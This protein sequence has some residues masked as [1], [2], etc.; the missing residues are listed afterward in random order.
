MKTVEQITFSS[1][2]SPLIIIATVIV[3]FL[4]IIPFSCNFEKKLVAKTKAIPDKVDFNLH[5]KPILSDRCF[6][7]HGPDAASREAGLRL[8]TEE[9]AFAALG[10]TEEEKHYAIIAGDVENSTLIQ[11]IYS[12]DPA[13]IM[14]TPESNLTVSEYEKT[15]LKKWVAQGAEWKEHWS[16]LPIEEPEI[17]KVEGAKS[18]QPIDLFILK[19]L[20]NQGLKSVGQ[21]KKEHLIRRVT[22]S[23]TGLPPTIAEI[24]AFLQDNNPDAYE[25]VV[26]RLLT[27]DAYAENMT[28][29]WLDIARYADSHG[30]QDDLERVMFPWR[31]WVIHAFKKNM[32]YD[33]FVTWQL[34]GDL[35][36]NATKEQII[37]TGFNRN[38][39]ITQ[40]GGVIPEEYRVEYV[41]D[42]TQTFATAFLGL[43]YEC[44]KCH[45]HKYDAIAQKDYFS[46]F[47]FFNNVPEK[48][49]IDY[50]EIPEP[51]VTLSKEEIAETLTFINNA[52]TLEEIK[53]MVM[54]EM[55]EP[56]QAHILARGAYDKPTTP[57][58]PDM[59]KSIMEFSGKYRQDRLGLADWLFSTNNPL[60]ARVT[61]N[62]LWQQCF[63]KGIVATPD[64][65][66]NQGALPTHPELLDWLAIELTDNAWD[67]KYILKKIVLSDTYK[68]SAKVTE[69][70][71][72]I[73]P[74]N[75]YLARAPRLR[76]PAEMIRDHA[77]AISG[78]LDK[79][80]GG[81]SVKPYQPDGL[82]AETIGG[83]GGSLSKYVLDKGS[84]IYR[85]SIY[86]FWKRTVPPPSMMIF[87][88]VSRDICSAK[89]PTTGTPLQALVMLNDPQ[90]IEA[91]RVLA[92]QT[93]EEKETEKERI[94]AM[95]RLATSRE[96][97]TD[98]LENLLAFFEGEKLRFD[99]KPEAAK[100][101]LSIGQYP[102]KELLSESEIAA[103]TMV[104]SAIFNLDETITR[105]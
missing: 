26:D 54:Q 24:D 103:Y 20:Q 78:L 95:F 11:R 31:D 52:D 57:V 63:G 69:E 37:A 91:A 14:P 55:S 104:A 29:S 87:D 85:R 39:K 53:L 13:E 64:D 49:L 33:E 30:Y 23:L 46:L 89:R 102:I 25:R 41:S 90:I 50:G 67:L 56:R 81:P 74:A 40:E 19:E 4:F 10:E 22:F 16:F 72:E 59:P 77:L 17:P 96:I 48:G 62:R 36:P 76:L 105:G 79:T 70:L 32:P 12:E 94:A 88:A 101:L 42:R 2:V 100:S 99:T 61:V 80:I 97:K 65:F 5:I 66:G 86:T 21:A 43:T 83:G 6:K 60:T 58:D 98:E 38:H 71:L 93:I 82:W 28:A 3:S 27:S 73:D 35:L 18:T 8:D 34:A 7:C 75:N 44:A 92:Y 1:K 51:Y 9:G 84:K 15:V 47:S 45:D 68:Q